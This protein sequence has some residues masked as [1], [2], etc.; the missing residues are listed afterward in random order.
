M[1]EFIGHEFAKGSL[2]VGVFLAVMIRLAAKNPDA[3]GGIA[4]GILDLLSRR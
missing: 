1:F 3:T 2:M 4:R